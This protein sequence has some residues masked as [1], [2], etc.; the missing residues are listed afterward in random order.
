MWFQIDMPSSERLAEIQFQSPVPGG[1]GAAVSASGAP[2]QPQ[3]IAG[4]GFPRAFKVEVSSDGAVWTTVGEAASRGPSTTLA[5]P[6][7]PANRF[8]ITLTADV[9]GGPAWS[10][11]DLR[12]L[13]VR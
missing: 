12:V 9:E 3:E 7:T 8:R 4:F 10:L 2:V 13:G 1:T 6:P 5:F 11:Q